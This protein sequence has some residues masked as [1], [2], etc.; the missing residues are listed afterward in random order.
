[1]SKLTFFVSFVLVALLVTCAWYFGEEL[2]HAA[3]IGLA[4]A[5]LMT[6][7]V[8]VLA[9]GNADEEEEDDQI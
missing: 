5:M 9:M 1:M 8:E 6:I 3:V 4:V 2:G 7:T